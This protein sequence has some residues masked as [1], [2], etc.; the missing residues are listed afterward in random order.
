MKADYKLPA[1][2]RL[3]TIGFLIV[4]CYSLA[5]AQSPVPGSRAG[6]LKGSVTDQRGKLILA[7]IITIEGKGFR[8]EVGYTED[9]NYRIDLP[10][11]HYRLT[12][13][14]RGFRTLRSNK[15]R[16]RAGVTKTINFRLKQLS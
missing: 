4:V 1:K 5:P 12:I 14:S 7:S 8:R 3:L 10:A 2:L 11:G 15:I 9:G 16:I 6:T 13:R